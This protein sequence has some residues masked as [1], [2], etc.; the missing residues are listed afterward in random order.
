MTQQ[1][2]D[3]FFSNDVNGLDASSKLPYFPA[4][5]LGIV[6]VDAIKAIRPRAGGR[7]YCVE[8][9]VESSNIPDVFVG[10]RYSWYQKIPDV[11][12][13]TALGNIIGF[14][15]AAVGLDPTRDAAKIAAEVKPNQQRILNDS[16]SSRQ[17]L[18]GARVQ[19]QTKVIV[20]KAKKQDFTLHAFSIAPPL[21]AA[22]SA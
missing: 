7:A 22:P 16:C 15:L 20:T 14:L 18:A 3:N 17:P 19:L 12:A 6:K 13:Q 2:T 21:A 4:N 5:F 1:A 8:F 9:S 10:G 11:D